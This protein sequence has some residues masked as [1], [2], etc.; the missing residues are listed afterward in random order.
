MQNCQ[1]YTKRFHL[2][3]FPNIQGWH[4]WHHNI[5]SGNPADKCIHI[6]TCICAYIHM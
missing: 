4:F 5:P 6:C 1:V 2:K 3:A